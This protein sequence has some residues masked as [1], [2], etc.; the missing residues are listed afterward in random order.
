MTCVSIYIAVAG[1][2][3]QLLISFS[4]DKAD[5][6]VMDVYNFDSFINLLAEPQESILLSLER[7]PKIGVRTRLGGYMDPTTTGKKGKTH[8]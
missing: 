7:K 6:L 4:C 2:Y 1:N 5:G 8:L 3:V